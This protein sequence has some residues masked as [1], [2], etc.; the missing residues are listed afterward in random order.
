MDDEEKKVFIALTT[1][2]PKVIIVEEK[3][4]LPRIE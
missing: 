4:F 3:H 1:G 2:T